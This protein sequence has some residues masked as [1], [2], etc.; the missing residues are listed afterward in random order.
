MRLRSTVPDW[1][2]C[3]QTPGI[4]RFPARMAD[5]WGAGCARS[6]A[7]PAAESALGFALPQCPILR[8]GT[9]RVDDNHLAVQ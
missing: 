1:G 3:P 9:S 2:R 6:R 8:S 7:I 4:F 5:H